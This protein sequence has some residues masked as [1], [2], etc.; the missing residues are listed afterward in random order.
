MNIS[1]SALSR[2]LT[3]FTE[4]RKVP[5]KVAFE[6]HCIK[7]FLFFC[8]FNFKA[9]QSF[10]YVFTCIANLRAGDKA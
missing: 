5:W 9:A 4:N 8:F 1:P 2:V 6:K 3:G 7:R 10:V